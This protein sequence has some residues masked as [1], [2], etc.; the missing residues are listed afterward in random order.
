MWDFNPI[1]L[2]GLFQ[3]DYYLCSNRNFFPTVWKLKEVRT[4]AALKKIGGLFPFILFY[5]FFPRF[6]FQ[7]DRS[8]RGFILEILHA[9]CNSF[10]EI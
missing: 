5:F 9:F 7:Q 8:K 2:S 10:I 1:F 4:P 3:L 6:W